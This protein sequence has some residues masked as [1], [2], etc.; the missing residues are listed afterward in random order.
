VTGCVDQ[1]VCMAPPGSTVQ[2]QRLSEL[3]IFAGDLVEQVPASGVVPYDVNVALYSDHAWKHRFA[4]VPAGA[5]LHFTPDRWALPLGTRL[6]KT[7]Y[8][9]S[10]MRD[11][12]K[13]GRLIETRIL[14]QEANGLRAG[15]YLW[16]AEQTDAQCSGGNLDVPTRWTDLDGEAHV[17]HFHVPGTSQCQTCHANLAL[18][19]RTRQMNRDGTFSDGSTNQI[20]HLIALGVLDAAPGERARLADPEGDAPLEARARAYLDANCGHCHRPDGVAASTRLFLDLES[21]DPGICRATPEVDG[22]TR[23]IVPGHPESSELLAR[24]RS[25][26]AFVRMPRGPTHLPDGVGLAL[27]SHWIA[28]MAPAGCR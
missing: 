15:T 26:D 1:P 25:P 22:A 2:A 9:P 19:L 11:P 3:G 10:D 5:Q 13:G 24:M 18:G 12:D 8:Y 14:T 20:D 23:V 21:A 6:V 7:F 17:D 28:A 4:I 27:L 16:N